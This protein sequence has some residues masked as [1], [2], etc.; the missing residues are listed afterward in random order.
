MRRINI[1]TVYLPVDRERITDH[2]RFVSQDTAECV[3]ISSGRLLYLRVVNGQHVA[4]TGDRCINDG[5]DV[6]AQLRLRGG[7][8]FPNRFLRVGGFCCELELSRGRSVVG[9]TEPRRLLVA[10][11]APPTRLDTER[12]DLHTTGSRRHDE[13]DRNH[14]VLI[15]PPD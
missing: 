6:A 11:S 7:N 12:G 13:G 14:S 5:P 4:G 15:P 8:I 2:A 9:T 3:D 10:T 1:R